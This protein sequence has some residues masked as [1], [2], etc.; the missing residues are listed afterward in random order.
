MSLAKVILYWRA[1]LYIKLNSYRTV[2]IATLFVTLFVL[3][4]SGI[5][6]YL[7]VFNTCQDLSMC[8][9]VHLIFYH[10]PATVS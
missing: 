8:R 10:K 5:R 6:I 9:E 2:N 1:D 3:G 4:D 7:H